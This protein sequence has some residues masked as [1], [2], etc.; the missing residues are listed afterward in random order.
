MGLKKHCCKCEQRKELIR[1]RIE[2]LNRITYKGKPIT[3]CYFEG[4]AI[5][6]RIGELQKEL[7]IN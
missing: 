7:D 4:I 6:R 5:R 3:A 1:V 2:E